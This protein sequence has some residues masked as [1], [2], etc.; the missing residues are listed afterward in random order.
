MSENNVIDLSVYREA[1]AEK[2][3]AETAPEDLAT[4]IKSLIQ[5]LRDAEPLL[6]TGS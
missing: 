4:A 3:S 5:R 6:S 1:V 2:T